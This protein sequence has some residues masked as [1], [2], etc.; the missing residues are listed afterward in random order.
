MKPFSV[1]DGT[2]KGHSHRRNNKGVICEVVKYTNT[3]SGCSCPV[4]EYDKKNGIPLG[5]GCHEC[6]H[7]GKRR[8]TMYIPIGGGL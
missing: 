7:T 3:C 2:R 5:M 1:E 8:M 4:M 6:G